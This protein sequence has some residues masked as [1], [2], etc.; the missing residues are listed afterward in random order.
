[1]KFRREAR[2]LHFFDRSSGLHVLLD[3]CPIPAEHVDEGPAIISIALTNACDLSCAFCYAPKTNHWLRSDDVLRWCKDLNELGTLE[4]AFGG[5]E[6]TLYRDLPQLCRSVW[7]GTDLGISITT[8][9]QHLTDE[10]VNSLQGAVSIIR[11]SIDGPEPYYSSIRGQHLQSLM[12]RLQ[13]VAGRIPLGINTVINPDTLPHLDEMAALVR[14]VGAVDWLLLPEVR[15]GEFI[16]SDSEWRVFDKWIAERRLDMDLRVATEAA[17]HLTCPLLLEDPPESYAHISADGHLRRC[18]YST[19]GI[20]L[21]GMTVAAALRGLKQ[22]SDLPL[23]N[24]VAPSSM[25][26]S[27]R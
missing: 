20:R 11:V 9:G 19:G 25:L 5:G 27:Q 7:S 18:S 17:K 1:V 8:H 6:P 24:Q 23:L 22:K 10:L 16:L 13:R 12:E 15:A 26:G 21:E 4:A 3:E 14:S 2:G